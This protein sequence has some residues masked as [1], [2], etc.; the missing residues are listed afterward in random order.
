MMNRPVSLK[1]RASGL[2]LVC[3]SVIWGVI[4]FVALQRSRYHAWRAQ[5]LTVQ[6]RA[7]LAEKCFR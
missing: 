3:G 5:A 6:P 4:E 7:A 1:T 2:L